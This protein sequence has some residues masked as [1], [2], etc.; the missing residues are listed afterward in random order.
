MRNLEFFSPA[1]EL[2][3]PRPRVPE[4]ASRGVDRVALRAYFELPGLY[5]HDTVVVQT[6]AVDLITDEAVV[7]LPDRVGG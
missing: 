6:L 2:S 5:T 7:K 4:R 3:A 1:W